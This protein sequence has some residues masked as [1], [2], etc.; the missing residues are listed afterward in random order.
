MEH[1]G[2][3]E[4]GRA[5]HDKISSHV[6]I[7]CPVP[8]PGALGF[9]TTKMEGWNMNSYEQKQEA[10]RERFEDLADKADREADGR[11]GAA[12]RLA[13]AIPFGQ[14]ILVGHHSEKRA[15]R[16]QD[17]IH[18]NMGKGVEAQKKA[19]YYRSKADGVGRAGI[20]GDDPDAPGQDPRAY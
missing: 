13:D 18:N 9:P 12:H 20:S 19:G 17:R 16:D 5:N 2:S 8:L 4:K 11:F 10:R 15:R 6:G 7:G 1:S 14:P 3:N